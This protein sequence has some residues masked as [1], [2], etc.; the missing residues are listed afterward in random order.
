MT[1][2]TGWGIKMETKVVGAEYIE[3][4][5]KLIR[6]GEVVA[7]PTETVYGLGASAFDENAVSKIFAAKGRP[8]DNPLIVH[9]AD[10]EM[11]DKVAVC[12]PDGAR[13]LFERFSPGPLTVILKKAPEIPLSVT[14][15]LDTVGIR[16]PSHPIA[17]ALIKA[18]GV[19]IA[20]P[21]ANTSKRISPTTAE[22]VLEDMNG[23][24]PMILDGGPCAVGIESTIV[25][26]TKDVPVVLRP[27]AITVEMLSEVLGTVRTFTGEVKIAEAPGMKYTH[28]APVVPCC[29][30]ATPEAATRF[31]SETPGAA[32]IG[33]EGFLD[34]ISGGEKIS[35]GK[36]AESME[37]GVYAAM[38][39]A[40][41]I[42][43][44]IVVELPSDTGLDASVRNRL[45][46][47]SGGKI[48]Y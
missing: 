36:D 22:H 12:I 39:R 4:A 23:K 10:T 33:R 28:Y 11:L 3:E 14:A 5:A 24:I 2:F 25:D 27:G 48:I 30:A 13:K 6:E 41:K 34:R 20:A 47:S 35:L 46:K 29:L 43:K 19:G 1:Y 17:T 32:V 18:A 8:Q 42:Y 44:A 31:L 38:R 21:S 7:F 9:I 37:Q 26:M 45:M 40:E 16:I 15:N